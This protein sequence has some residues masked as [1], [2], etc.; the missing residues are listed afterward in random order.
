MFFKEFFYYWTTDFGEYVIIARNNKSVF[1]SS[2]WAE[3]KFWITAETKR[4]IS[5]TRLLVLEFT[6]ISTSTFLWQTLSLLIWHNMETIFST[7]LVKGWVYLATEWKNR[8]VTGEYLDQKKL[9]KM[10]YI[11]QLWKAQKETP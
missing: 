8:M 4:W 1:D 5:N 11:S 10:L 2:S 3:T 7:I 9:Q 6:R